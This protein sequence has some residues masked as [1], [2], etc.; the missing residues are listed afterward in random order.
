MKKKEYQRVWLK[1]IKLETER[2]LCTS[3]N[4]ER[5]S[6]EEDTSEEDDWT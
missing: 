3:G 6:L 5:R 1:V 4:I 2:F